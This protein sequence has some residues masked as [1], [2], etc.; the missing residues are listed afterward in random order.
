MS[1]RI[2]LLR[3]V[4][5]GGTS[6]LAM[7]DLKRIGEEAGLARARTYIASG[8]LLGASDAG[9]DEL[10][11]ALEARLERHLGRPVLTVTRTRSE[12][13]RIVHANPF[14]DADPAKT[15]VIFLNAPAAADLPKGASG[16]GRETIVAS[17]REIYVH[18]PDGIGRSKLKI[19]AASDGT[20]RN[21]N[22]LTSLLTIAGELT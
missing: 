1:V 10:R 5:V 14:P 4:N 9:E 13:A 18:Y 22:T 16:V 3:A 19:P 8:N 6:K 7:T 11:A 21:I 17:G 20:A 15:V 2:V 12:L